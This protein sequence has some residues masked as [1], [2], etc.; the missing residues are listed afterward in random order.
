MAL[1]METTRPRL[2]GK[3]SLLLVR[4]NDTIAR[5]L[6]YDS[7]LPDQIYL[8]YTYTLTYTLWRLHDPACVKSSNRIITIYS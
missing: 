8:S 3:L 1:L 5:S 2:G 7:P 6:Q 4:Y